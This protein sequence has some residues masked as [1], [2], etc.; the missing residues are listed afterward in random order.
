MNLE[1][2]IKSIFMIE[3]DFR[4]LLQMLYSFQ[5][6]LCSCQGSTELNYDFMQI[7][8]SPASYQ[9]NIIKLGMTGS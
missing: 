1:L 6:H 9:P 7:T 8:V 3:I 4:H 2:Q 5:T